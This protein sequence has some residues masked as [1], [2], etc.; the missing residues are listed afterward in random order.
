[1][2]QILLTGLQL[3]ELRAWISQRH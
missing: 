1:M 3:W 2:H